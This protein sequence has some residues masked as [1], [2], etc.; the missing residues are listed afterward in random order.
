MQYK[1]ENNREKS[2]QK[3]FEKSIKLLNFYS[4]DQK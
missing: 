3:F 1:A 4:G 2:K